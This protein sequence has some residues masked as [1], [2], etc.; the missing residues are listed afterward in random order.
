MIPFRCVLLRCLKKEKEKEKNPTDQ[1]QLG[2]SLPGASV[3]TTALTT[4]DYSN[5]RS[6]ETTATKMSLEKG[7]D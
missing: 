7:L 5:I 3:V 4:F 2:V 1:K 6:Q